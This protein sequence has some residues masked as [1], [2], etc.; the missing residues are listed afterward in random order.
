LEVTTIK[1]FKGIFASTLTPFDENDEINYKLLK[2]QINYIISKG[3][4]GIVAAGINGE[5][6]SMDLTERKKVIETSIE[7]ADNRIPVIAGAYSTSWKESLELVKFAEEKGASAAILTT[8]FF[9]RKPTDE[10]LYQYFSKILTKAKKIPIFLCNVPIY[11]LIELNHELIE[12]L[13]AKFKNIVGIKD[14]SG[15]PDSITA[16]AGVFENLSV[17]I[18][19]D[20]LVFHGLNVQCDGAFSAIASIFPEYVLK[21]YN[22]YK[23]GKVD[24]AWIEQEALTGIRALLKR[25][26]SR[27][28][29][30]FIFSRIAGEESFVRAPLR[31][32]NPENKE[33]LKFILEDHGLLATSQQTQ[34]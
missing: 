4:H 34:K 24:Q 9:F 17:F 8:P 1:K 32:L 2:K 31:N 6:S 33:N 26:P 28:A 13:V 5:F 12:N 21:I 23:A 20:R 19:S 18:G 22:I 29:Q 16:Y 11:S 27:S 7:A 25:F 30:K 10:G 3:V 14:L 15:K